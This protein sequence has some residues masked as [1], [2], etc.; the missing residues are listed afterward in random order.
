[1]K[2]CLFGTI[3]SNTDNCMSRSHVIECVP[4]K[5]NEQLILLIEFLAVFFSYVISKL[6]G[7]QIMYVV[8][9]VVA[10]IKITGVGTSKKETG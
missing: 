8:V 7:N 10:P 4:V 3:F 2:R 5:H 1:M 9:T 6:C